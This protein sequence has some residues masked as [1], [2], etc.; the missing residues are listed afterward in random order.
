MKAET[1]PNPKTKPTNKYTLPISS[2][3]KPSPLRKPS[4]T[5]SSY[6]SPS[7]NIPPPIPPPSNSP[8]NSSFVTPQSSFTA[9]SS[10]GLKFPSP[11]AGSL[12]QSNLT[13]LFQNRNGSSQVHNTAAA[14]DFSKVEPTD[15]HVNKILQDHLVEDVIDRVDSPVLNVGSVSHSLQGG[16]LS[17]PTLFIN[18]DNRSNNKRYIQM[19]RIP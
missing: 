12:G 19:V 11:A 8:S 14:S 15:D 18:D 10:I 13:A 17:F 5:P 16:I 3:L 2:P 6:S 9:A 1:S 7:I 4:T